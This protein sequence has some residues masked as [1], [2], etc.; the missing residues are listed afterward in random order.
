MNV[1]DKIR[2]VKL[3]DLN[4]TW[5]LL[6]ET[7]DKG[8]NSKG[9][10]WVRVGGYYSSL[11]G[12]LLGIRKYLDEEMVTSSTTIEKYIETLKNTKLVM[13][14]IDNAKAK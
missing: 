5:E 7:K 9:T 10:S 12:A 2:I 1:I 14:V 4:L 11:E 3:D 8:G 6:K 13:E